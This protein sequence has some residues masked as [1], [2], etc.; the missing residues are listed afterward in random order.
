M[1]AVLQAGCRSGVRRKR[2]QA[3]SDCPPST[4][5]TCPVIQR[6]AGEHRN[7]AARATSS[8]S[9][10]PPNGILARICSYSAGSSLR[11][12]SHRPPGN[13]MEPGAMAL[14]R[15]RSRASSVA[16]DVV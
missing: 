9:P 12:R 10:K 8:T 2:D 3:G 11:R 16:S 15:M 4:A 1:R 14:T 13:S 6:A 7:T 5:S